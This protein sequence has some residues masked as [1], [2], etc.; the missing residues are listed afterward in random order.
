[1]FTLTVTKIAAPKSVKVV[2]SHRQMLIDHLKASTTRHGF[3]AV[4]D[5]DREGFGLPRSGD[6]WRNGEIVALWEIT[7]GDWR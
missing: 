6:I 2:A 4:T 3:E 1:M 7:E 5:K